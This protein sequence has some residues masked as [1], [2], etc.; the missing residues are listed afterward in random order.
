MTKGVLPLDTLKY[1]VQWNTGFF[2][3]SST[4]WN[5][6]M[7]TCSGNHDGAGMS[8]GNL[9][10]NFGSANHLTELWQYMINNYEQV[11]INAFGTNTTEYNT[12]KT[13]MLSTVQ[14]DRLNFG[15]NISDPN[16]LHAIIEPYKTSLGNLL[17]TTECQARY[18]WIR[19][20]YY[21]GLPYDLFRRMSCTSRMALASFFDIYINRGRCYPIN[22]LQVDFENIDA[23]T[24]LT[25]DQKELQKIKQI[26]FRANEEENAMSDSGTETFR[27]RRDSM[28]NYGGTYY[29]LTYAPDTQFDI[30]LEPGS[31]EKIDTVGV[32]LGSI[33]V[34][35]VY[36]GNTPVQSIYLGANLLGGSAA[37]Y[38][39]T[40]A[41]QT[42]IRTNPSSYAGIGTATS[43]T[44]NVGQ[45]IWIDVQNFVACKTYYT[46]DGTEP[47]VNST[48]Y[49]APITFDAT[50]TFKC[51]TI[52][53][54]GVA[55][56]TKTITVNVAVAPTT[57]IAPTATVQ[58]TI[59]FTVT[60]T[61]SEAGAQI[62]YMLGTSST[63]YSY[64]APFTVN[65]NSAGVA[66]TQIKITYWAVGASATE[67]QKI[68]TYDTAGAI[69]GKPAVTATPGNGTVSLS[70][71][72]TA[73]TTSYS[74]YRSTVAGTLGTALSQYQTGTTYNDSGLTAGTT[75][76]YTV[77]SGN[78]QTHTDT[79]VSAVPTA[80]PAK[81]TYRYLRIL[82]YG[83]ATDATTRIIELEVFSGGVNRMTGATML[84]SDA[85]NNTGT[86]AQIK[87]GVK[88]T[89]AN[90]YPYWWST[91]PNAHVVIDLLAQ[92]VIDSMSYYS[93]SLTGDQ[94][95]N[96][97][98]IQGS[99]TNNGT[100]WVDIWDN[101]SVTS[102]V[103]PIL[104]S[105]YTKTF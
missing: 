75:Y 80:P 39:T 62:K 37:P 35:N 17:L 23:D 83:T 60:L 105:G 54:D 64:T 33:A 71:G 84:S 14:Q 103:Q 94:R 36:L 29:G 67:A 15:A 28:G 87:D 61:T 12:W 76:Y 47:T 97:F 44:L 82:G 63:V 53:L 56:A 81:P 51:K 66:S 1:D 101:S 73:N 16:N 55:E 57:T 65:Q 74:I 68:I 38:T 32:N 26:N 46:K 42:Q 5:T 10:I 2:E 34:Q 102:P 27:P 59:P 104:P 21:W 30:N 98:I 48:L 9:Q 85:P 95:I 24:T 91:V 88:T 78:Y 58:N 79:T 100:D 20:T 96:R 7:A 25:A 31:A 19:D 89:T 6:Q 86:I 77:Q 43:I 52:S 13:A 18:A 70:W 8:A 3:C 50:C 72:A 92:Y 45:P 49:N 40:K 11:C 90:S 4:N 41:P 99:N 93:V 22:L 69:P